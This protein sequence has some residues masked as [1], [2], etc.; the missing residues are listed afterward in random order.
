MKP[1]AQQSDALT[2]IFRRERGVEFEV[3]R[4][5]VSSKVVSCLLT[6]VSP[7]YDRTLYVQPYQSFL[8][9]GDGD[10]FPMAN[11]FERLHLDR[12]QAIT[13]R[14][15]FP[16]NKNIVRP[17]HVQVVGAI[18]GSYFEKGFEVK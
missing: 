6:V 2:G 11:Q 5:S 12:S 1:S 4:S 13:F 7:T 10:W 15:T 8:L 9:D 14:M 17:A 18:D 16:V 3:K